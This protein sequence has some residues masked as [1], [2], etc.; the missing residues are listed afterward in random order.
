MSP[1]LGGRILSHDQVEAVLMRRAG[2]E[3]RL[4]AIED[5]SYELNPPTAI[6]FVKRDLRWCQ[7]NLQYLKLLGVLD[8][9][10]IGRI[11][12][13]LAILMYVNAPA[14]LAFTALALGR[15]ALA[16]DGTS[17]SLEAW[18]VLALVLAL[19]MAPKLLGTL[20]VLL[21]PAAAAAYGGRLRVLLTA[22]LE[23]VFSLVLT[24]LLLAAQ[25]IFMLRMLSGRSLTWGAQLRSNRTV[26]WPEALMSLRSQLALGTLALC[27]ASAVPASLANWALLLGTALL[28]GIPFAVL[29]SRPEIGAL[30]VRAGLAATPEELAPP[31]VVEAAGHVLRPAPE[32]GTTPAPVAGSQL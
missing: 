31:P 5:G 1:P 14:W 28:A 27:L 12:L 15:G 3:V 7:G 6:E 8:T 26:R 20:A 11:Q 25:A 16:P 13:F 4:L 24:P 23:L 29:T 2:Y 17:S 18:L 30:L 21:R 10:L 22:T 32:I 9:H 19:A